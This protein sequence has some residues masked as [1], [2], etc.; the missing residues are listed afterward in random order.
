MLKTMVL[1]MTMK[2]DQEMLPPKS[3]KIR[4]LMLQLLDGDNKRVYHLRLKRH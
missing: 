3:Y 1:R 2:K 4:T